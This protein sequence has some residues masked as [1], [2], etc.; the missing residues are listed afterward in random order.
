VTDYRSINEKG[1]TDMVK[2]IMDHDERLNDIINKT[3]KLLAKKGYDNTSIADI[4]EKVGIAK[5]TFYH[6]F[7][8]KDDLLDAIVD[9]MFHKI[10]DSV[11]VIVANDDLDA[12]GKFLKAFVA[13]RTIGKG[14]EK[15]LKDIH[16]KE[17]AHI[18]LKI[19]SKMYPEIIPKFEKI[20]HQGIDEGVFDT[21]YPKEA[22]T[23][24]LISISALT[25]VKEHANNLRKGVTDVDSLVMFFDLMERILG[26]KRGIFMRYMKKMEG[27][28]GK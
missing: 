14:Q 2:I 23:V 21:K 24:I 20:I 8:S 12:I 5:G 7:S 6:Y 28:R 9:R 11:E 25:S 18:H 26:A 13:F 19:E 17:N 1:D 22:A 4:I 10:W 16:K 15:V 3:E 27:G